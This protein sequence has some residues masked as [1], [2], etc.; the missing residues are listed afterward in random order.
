MSDIKWSIFIDSIAALGLFFSLFYYEPF[1]CT[2]IVAIFFALSQIF[3]L[4]FRE[5]LNKIM[6]LIYTMIV[7]IVFHFAGQYDSDVLKNTGKTFFLLYVFVFTI[8]M[9]TY[10]TIYNKQP[11]S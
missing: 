6:Y 7:F 11:N 8:I 3:L 4:L 1:F 2:R 5:S 10:R 9:S